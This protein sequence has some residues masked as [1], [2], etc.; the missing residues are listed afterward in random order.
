MH[1]AFCY[2][3]SILYR[4]RVANDKIADEVIDLGFG[5]AEDLLPLKGVHCTQ[6]RLSAYGKVVAVGQHDLSG[7]FGG[8]ADKAVDVCH[9]VQSDL[10]SHN[11]I[12]LSSVRRAYG[13]CLRFLFFWVGIARREVNYV[14]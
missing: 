1:G 2:V 9:G 6:Q 5:F 12:I 13:L 14:F 3:R 10:V 11:F 8:N 4:E 7:V